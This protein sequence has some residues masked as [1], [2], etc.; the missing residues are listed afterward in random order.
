VTVVVDCKELAERMYGNLIQRA[1]IVSEKLGR[2]PGLAVI[3]LGDDPASR[4]YLASKKRQ[5]E[6]CGIDLCEIKLGGQAP[7]EELI[8]LLRQKST[9]RKIDGIMIELP[10]PSHLVP[11][12][13]QAVL[14][15]IKDIEGVTPSNA[16]R[17]F[18]GL[19]AFVPCTAKAAMY[20]L[21]TA[22]INLK[23]KHAVVVGASNIVGKPLALL[24]LQ[25][26]AT[27]EIC[28]IYTTDLASR[29]RQADILFVAA[30]VP[31]LITR[32]MVKP[33]AVVVDIGINL[34]GG[35]IV[36]DV[37]FAEVQAVT[38]LITPVPGGVGALTTAMLLENVVEAAEG[39]LR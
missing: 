3:R 13:L 35:K 5:S 9:D 25:Q 28:H 38:S 36:G 22:Q 31:G 23:G 8:E 18:M 16:G 27:V 17:L 15:P 32:E 10:L 26:W 4:V 30:G 29:T 39:C 1:T 7:A 21:G 37:D 2:R 14:D 6:L 24:L 12:Q 34:V 11:T 20:V 19:P 33:G